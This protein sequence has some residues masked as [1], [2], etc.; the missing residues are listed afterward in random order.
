V[1]S[2]GYVCPSGTLAAG[3]QV[4]PGASTHFLM[5]SSV[6]CGVPVCWLCLVLLRLGSCCLM[7]WTAFRSLC[8]LPF[9]VACCACFL[10]SCN[11]TG[12]SCYNRQLVAHARSLLQQHLMTTHTVASQSTA[13]S[14]SR[15]LQHECTRAK[16]LKCNINRTC[17]PSQGAEPFSR[18]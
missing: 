3:R 11:W 18:V 16:D 12:A 6:V 14:V 5:E 2:Q 4:P 10:P 8:S 7:F 9:I 1:H 13:L 15:P 17:I